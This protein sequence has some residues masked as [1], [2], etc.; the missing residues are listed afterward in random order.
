MNIISDV[1]VSRMILTLSVGFHLLMW[2]IKGRS[3]QQAQKGWTKKVVASRHSPAV[4]FVTSI[5]G[6]LGWFFGSIAYAAGIEV[7]TP[8]TFLDPMIGTLVLF[9]GHLLFGW[10]LWAIS[11]SLGLRPQV[12]AEHR[13]V[14]HGPYRFAR[15]PMYTALHAMYLGTF[16]LVPSWFFL[17]CFLAAVVGNVIRAR[18]EEKVLLERYGEEYATYARSTGR[19]F[20]KV[21][22]QVTTGGPSERS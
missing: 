19:F 5:F 20:P 7:I 3:L 6:Y 12:I 8:F 14:T 1:L 17:A 9:L 11:A 21:S 15:H 18:E 2:M 4:G 22:D 10:T 13:L 16:L